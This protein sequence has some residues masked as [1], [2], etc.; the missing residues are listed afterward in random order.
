VPPLTV[1]HAN[2]GIHVDTLGFSSPDH[3]VAVSEPDLQWT[4]HEALSYD[5]SVRALGKAHVR[6]SLAGFP[7]EAYMLDCEFAALV[8]H[9][10]GHGLLLVVFCIFT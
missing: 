3:E 2:D 6:Q 7:V 1:L 5:P 4:A 10:Y 8:H 9:G